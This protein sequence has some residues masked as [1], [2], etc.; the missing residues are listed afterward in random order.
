MY[1]VLV[2][3]AQVTQQ[4]N[5]IEYLIFFCEIK[6]VILQFGNDNH[7]NFSKIMLV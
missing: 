6:R 5:I 2:H 7:Y 4:S 3:G 1:N